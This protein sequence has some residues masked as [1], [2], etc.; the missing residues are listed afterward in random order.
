MNTSGAC[1]PLSCTIH[2]VFPAVLESD[3]VSSHW[4]LSAICQG[5]QGSSFSLQVTSGWPVQDGSM[6]DVF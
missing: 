3:Q 4:W 1:L 2:S 6:D 5:L